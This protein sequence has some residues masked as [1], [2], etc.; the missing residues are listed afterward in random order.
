MDTRQELRVGDSVVQFSLNV[1]EGPR[2][3]VR[4]EP[5]AMDVLRFLLERPGEVLSRREILD[6]VWGGR[7]VS[8]E[9]LTN[10]ISQI[11]RAFGDAARTPRY[12]ETIAKG[13]YRFIAP[14]IL[15]PAVEPGTGRLPRLDWR[16][17]ASGLGLFAVV[18]GLWFSGGKMPEEITSSEP[19]PSSVVCVKEFR[20]LSSD[21][22]LSW[23]KVGIAELMVT[24]MSQESRLSIL[25]PSEARAT[26]ELKRREGIEIVGTFARLGERI[27]IDTYAKDRATRKIIAAES[28]EAPSL[29]DLFE[30]VD[31]LAGR[32]SV[33]LQMVHDGEP[34]LSQ[35]LRSVVT[36]DMDAYRHFVEGMRTYYFSLDR[37]AA[38][39]HYQ[40][41]VALDPG[42]A[43]AHAKLAIV[44]MSVGDLP[45]ANRAARLAL[46]HIERLPP[47]ER[48]YVRGNFYV[49]R[50]E[51][52]SEAVA[53][54]RRALLAEPGHLGARHNLGFIYFRLERYH[55]A[56]EML[57]PIVLKGVHYPGSHRLLA[58]S[59]AALGQFH[60]AERVV[61]GYVSRHPEK[62][63]GHHFLA[64]H[65]MRSG[66]LGE[67]R[68][69]LFRADALRPV[70]TT[71]TDAWQLNVLADRWDTGLAAADDHGIPHLGTAM[72]HLYAG[73]VQPALDAFDA[74]EPGS[75]DAEPWSPI[76]LN[77]S[78]A[79]RLQL[80][81]A[82]GALR[83][84][85][86]ARE[87]GAGNT[88]EWGGLAIQAQVHAA[89]QNWDEA[90]RLTQELARRTKHV[91]S[92]KEKRRLAH[93]QGEIALLR[94]DWDAARAWLEQ[95]EAL[96]PPRGFPVTVQLPQH[97]PIRYA[98]AEAYRHNGNVDEAIDWYASVAES[99][100][101]RIVWPVLYVRSFYHLG[102]LLE[103]QGHH[104]EAV[105]CYERFLSFWGKGELD[106]ERILAARRAV[107]ARSWTTQVQQRA[108]LSLEF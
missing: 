65:F 92:V 72:R 76:W 94:E 83:D 11:R 81:D 9:V 33:R 31:V 77:L 50:E 106:R 90:R 2:G 75:Y 57:R 1:V 78:S 14:V 85:R 46:S 100:T 7:F 37:A 4:L 87:H 18:A 93:L 88:A 42:F 30:T 99:S 26:G 40:K 22:E 51:T 36:N 32:L 45:S 54:Y 29:D 63:V 82:K 73:D 39:S 47:H 6:R 71:H 58:M 24:G 13:G 60:D 48:D 61:R 69:A 101:E 74:M 38:L 25:G 59:H 23:L 104:S 98:L 41:A 8:D 19:T 80:G 68:Q 20:D 53:A 27:R 17:V 64:Q 67:A 35:S 16:P 52:F 91:P 70:Q 62:W 12:I 3:K 44:Q 86:W 5:K 34:Y 108:A 21:T 97:V 95:A 103:N 79:T 96:L 15:E 55:E 107:S 84:A 49:T 102:A 56:I 43:M 10:A 105:R 28:A 66:H 89:T